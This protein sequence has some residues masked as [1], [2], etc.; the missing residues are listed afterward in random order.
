MK[1]TVGRTLRVLVAHVTGVR[2]S[3]CAINDNAFAFAVPINKPLLK[4]LCW[5]VVSEKQNGGFTEGLLQMSVSDFVVTAFHALSCRFMRTFYQDG[6]RD[7]VS[8]RW[9]SIDVVNLIKDE[10]RKNRSNAGNSTK[11]KR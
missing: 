10:Q 8:H 1:Y 2:P 11:E 5:F 7:K 6:I 4:P 9:E 3:F